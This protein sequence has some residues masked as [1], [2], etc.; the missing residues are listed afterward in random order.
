MQLLVKPGIEK[1][2][3]PAKSISTIPGYNT[4]QSM[5]SCLRVNFYDYLTSGLPQRK[6][7]AKN[8]LLS[9]SRVLKRWIEALPLTNTSVA[10]RMLFQVLHELNTI[11]LD[12]ASRLDALENL[13]TPVVRLTDAIDRQIIGSTFPLPLAKVQLGTVARDFHHQMAIGYRIALQDLCGINGKV[14]FL[15]GKTVGLTLE[16]A[17]FH[18]GC[19]LCK[20]YFLY[21]MP[22]KGVWQTLHALF[23]YAKRIGLDEKTVEDSLRENSAITPRLTYVEVVLLAL[24]NPYRLNQKEIQESYLLTQLWAPQVQLCDTHSPKQNHALPMD[25]DHGPGY[26]HEERLS[27]NNALLSFDTSTLENELS[28][29]VSLAKSIGGHLTFSNKGTNSISVSAELVS[30]LLCSWQKETE[31]NAARQ[32]AGYQLDTL[33]GFHS[34]HFHLAG[35]V[36]FETYVKRT[37]G[38]AVHASERERTSSWANQ[39]N[40]SIKPE[41]Q[42]AVVLNQSLGGYRI[43][44]DK[45]EHIRARVGE[46]IAVCLPLGEGEPEHSRDWMVG[47][48]RWLRISAEGA[49]DA[50]VHLLSRTPRPAVLRSLDQN[51]NPKPSVRAL[52]LTP[53]DSDELSG[54]SVLAPIVLDRHSAR[55]ELRA[56]P[57]R[58]SDQDALDIHSLTRMVITDQTSSYLQLS[59]S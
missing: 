22:R 38:T 6:Q 11:L 58:Y 35:G 41:I 48:I 55:Y 13:R 25:E 57:D 49:I 53:S 54:Y 26:L 4:N 46:L 40:E 15:R 36:D 23:G 30:T 32:P 42:R 3:C 7:A 27:N 50:G 10:A 51:G 44:W 16:R 17:L 47:V 18:L 43:L 19:E 2:F 33:F 45:G 12:P 5:R 39:S 59:A 56:S 8:T 34:L 14:P 9:D 20:G 37:C 24:S 28:R 52:V 29:Q 1:V 21:A 31:R